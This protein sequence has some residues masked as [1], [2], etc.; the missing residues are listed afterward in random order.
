MKTYSE[1]LSSRRCFLKRVLQGGA[2]LSVRQ[3][4]VYSG[5]SSEVL[6][7]FSE[8]EGNTLFLNDVELVLER[9]Y[10]RK[11]D[12]YTQGF[13]YEF[14]TALSRG[15]LYE[16]GGRYGRSLLRKLDA[17]SGKI[18]KQVKIPSR[19][20][21]E[22]LVAVDDRL[23]IL[24]WREHTCLVYNKQT[25]E[26]VD[27]FRY[28]GEGWGLTFDGGRLIMSD[29]SSKIHFLDPKTFKRMK[30]IDVHFFNNFGKRRPINNLNELEYINNEIWANVYQQE[31]VVRIDP[32]T[33]SLIGTAINFSTLT[34][35]SLKSST[36]YVLNGLAFDKD[37]NRLYV[38]GKCWPVTY[39]FNINF[40]GRMN[41][42]N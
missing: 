26:Q 36:E 32:V 41:E 29:G 10:S 1:L 27:E 24:T 11:T 21:A 30:T 23:Y 8:E 3:A 28:S 38:T 2:F 33:G 22:G 9:K 15:V 4:L 12:S 16:S 17:E 35:K 40:N 25:F 6:A 39:I 42:N 37:N 31:Y 13:W 5:T 18:L 19:Y 7:S 20:F 34:P 14:D